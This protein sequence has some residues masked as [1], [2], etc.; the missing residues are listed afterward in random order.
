MP[1]V[2]KRIYAS[3]SIDV[4]RSLLDLGVRGAR[5]FMAITHPEICLAPEASRSARTAYARGT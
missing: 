1:Q 2:E 3:A 5:V 4:Q